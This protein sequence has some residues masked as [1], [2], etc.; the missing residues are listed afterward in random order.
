MKVLGIET[1]CDETG[2][3]I[4]ESSKEEGRLLDEVLYSQIESHAPLGGVLPELAAREHMARLPHLL[5]T[6]LAKGHS[7]QSIDLV[8]YTATPGLLGALSVGVNFAKALALGLQIPA[9]GVHHLE[10]HLLSPLLSEKSPPPPP[11]AVLLVSG[12]HTQ[13]IKVES[14]GVYRVLGEQLDDALG[15]VFDKVARLLGLPYPGGK[16]LSELAKRGD[17]NAFDFPRP[18]SKKAG[19][20][21]SFSGLKTK[22][23]YTVEALTKDGAP[24]SE[25]T[26]SNLA[27]AFEKAAVEMCAKS[28]CDVCSKKRVLCPLGG[29]GCGGESPPS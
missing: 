12:G 19:L 13:L 16:A 8:A 29:G 17:D 2:L 23:R 15:E 27:A 24:L 4:Y 6:L 18:L 1:S 25:S 21:L 10:S 22:V 26:R 28:R 20:D 11:W 9:L 5:N 3:A 7:L 14:M